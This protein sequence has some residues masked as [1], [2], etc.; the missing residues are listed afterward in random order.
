MSD[1]TTK[2]TPY[3]LAT[4]ALSLSAD[5]DRARHE[6]GRLALQARRDGVHNYL[7]IIGKAC[8]RQE[9]TVSHWARTQMWIDNVTV[10]HGVLPIIGLRYSF[11][12]KCAQ[13]S[14]RLDDDV[15][16]ESLWTWHEE[17]G[18]T[19][20]SFRAH[21]DTLAGRDGDA[22]FRIRVDKARKSVLSMIDQAPTRRGA[23]FLRTAADALTDALGELEAVTA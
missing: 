4:R 20:E 6:L 16:Y 17:E 19:L 9:S 5:I 13:V 18:A 15:L 23:D 3:T 21:L 7:A 8:R 14:D 11:F 2:L 1:K 10:T 12:E 22:D